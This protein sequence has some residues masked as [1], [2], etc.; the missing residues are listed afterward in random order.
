MERVSRKLD[1]LVTADFV[2]DDGLE[3]ESMMGEAE[4]Q[5]CSE[6]RFLSG[7]GDIR[8][9]WDPWALNIL[10]T[11]EQPRS[12]PNG[13]ILGLYFLFAWPSICTCRLR[14][15]NG[16]LDDRTFFASHN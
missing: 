15:L 7:I 1:A 6:V 11:F 5:G 13:H 16:F 4:V 3:D 12:Q 14:T 2:Q 9:H 10:G 8:R